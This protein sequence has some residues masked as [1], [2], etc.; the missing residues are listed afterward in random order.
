M[1]NGGVCSECRIKHTSYQGKM[2][3]FKFGRYTDILEIL[4]KTIFLDSR[5]YIKIYI[6]E[7]DGAAILEIGE[8]VKVGK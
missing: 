2:I 5:L 4:K 7:V 8:Q 1:A 3:R 6:S